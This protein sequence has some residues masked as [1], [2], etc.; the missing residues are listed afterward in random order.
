MIIGFFGFSHN[1][2][3]VIYEFH[4]IMIVILISDTS[5]LDLLRA[6]LFSF[7]SILHY[8]SLCKVLHVTREELNYGSAIIMQ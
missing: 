8:D 1:S 3:M 7:A 2:E 6:G 4:F 5:S